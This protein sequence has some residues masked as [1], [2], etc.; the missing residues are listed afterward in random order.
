MCG[1][2][3]FYSPK[4]VFSNEDLK[5]MTEALV[6]RGPDAEGYFSDEVVGLGHR[7]LSI[8]DL[9]SRANQPM[10]SHDGRYVIIYNGE[11]YNFQEI[12]ANLK[13]S[14]PLQQKS[15]FNTSSD[16]EVILE[17]FAQQGVDFVQHLNGMFA[18]AIYD[19]EKKDLYL[20]RDRV[21]IKPLYYFFDGENFAF[22]SE[23]KALMHLKFIPREIDKTAVRDFLH[24]GYIPT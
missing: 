24:L 3:G 1:I 20:F 22:A 2:A 18:I 23:I 8:L 4:K 13:F 5:N 15:N 16:T 14:V 17:A 12:A 19:K 11:V 10:Y 6:H 7:R 21:G 9:S